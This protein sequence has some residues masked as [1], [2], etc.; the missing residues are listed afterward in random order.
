M[1]YV[2]GNQGYAKPYNPMADINPSDIENV[3]VLKDGAATTI[4]GSF[5]K[6]NLYSIS[7]EV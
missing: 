2:A 6:T 3:E 5:R 1:P 7:G 4:Y